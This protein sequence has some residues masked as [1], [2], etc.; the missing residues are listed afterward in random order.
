MDNRITSKLNIYTGKGTR[1]TTKIKHAVVYNNNVVTTDDSNGI[2][3]YFKGNKF[4]FNMEKST[5]Q[6]YGLLGN[7]PIIYVNKKIF[8]ILVDKYLESNGQRKLSE[9]VKLLHEDVTYSRMISYNGEVYLEK[10]LNNE[11][12]FYKLSVNEVNNF[13]IDTKEI[14]NEEFLT[15]VI[16]NNAVKEFMYNNLTSINCSIEIKNK[17]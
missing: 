4:K 7:Y 15:I 3:I 1:E 17:A 12:L 2:L 13:V 6:Y 16:K 14:T 9:F 5:I 11:K 10:W 8:I